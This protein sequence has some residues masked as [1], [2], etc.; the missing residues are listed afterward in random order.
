MTYS[1]RKLI[2]SNCQQSG[3]EPRIKSWGASLIHFIDDEDEQSF[4]ATSKGYASYSSFPSGGFP[5][6]GNVAVNHAYA[7]P[8]IYGFDNP[9]L[10]HSQSPFNPI[11]MDNGNGNENGYGGF[12]EN[13]IGIGIDDGVFSSDGLMLLPLTEME[14]E[15]GLLFVNG[16]DLIGILL[17]ST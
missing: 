9:N 7:L 15:E 13:D 5:A 6:D 16:G 17:R 10:G 4:T 2:R 11:H 14:L 12:G 1:S 8:E 3:T